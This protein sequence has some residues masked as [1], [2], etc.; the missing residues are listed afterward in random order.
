MKT[1]FPTA[2]DLAFYRSK[3]TPPWAARLAGGMASTDLIDLVVESHGGRTCP[4]RGELAALNLLAILRSARRLGELD[5]RLRELAAHPQCAINP[6]KR[7]AFA[8]KWAARVG[9][10]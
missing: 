1:R 9:V 5:L 6:E 3:T 2:T 8:R 10:V 4:A 7:A